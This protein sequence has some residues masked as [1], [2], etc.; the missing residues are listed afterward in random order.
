MKVVIAASKLAAVAGLH[1]YKARADVFEEFVRR[2]APARADPTYL[3]AEQTARKALD[4][5]PAEAQEVVAQAIH[6]ARSA[7]TAQEVM[8]L[9]PSDVPAQVAE[10]ARSAMSTAYGT[11]SENAARVTYGTAHAQT[12]T[13]D[14]VYTESREPWFT[15]P[16]P[17]VATGSV[18]VFLGGMHDGITRRGDAGEPVIVEIKNRMRRFL[19]AP[20]YE[21]IQVLA[22]MHIFGVRS[23]V[24]VESYKGALREHPLEFDERLW[25]DV[26]Q[27]TAGFITEVIAGAEL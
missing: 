3:S 20:V 16:M 9:V 12:V 6:S 2:Y 15:L 22:Y 17:G 24:L 7:A 26:R 4:D 13:K 23:A 18:E 25:E 11:R 21:R 1:P 5:L 19:G 27:R 14:D 8:A 10:L